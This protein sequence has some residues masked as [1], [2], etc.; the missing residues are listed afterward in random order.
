MAD[1]CQHKN[2]FGETRHTMIWSHLDDN[3]G[4]GGDIIVIT[5]PMF[6]EQKFYYT[7]LFLNPKLIEEQA[8]ESGS[9][10][11]RAGVPSNESEPSWS[12]GIKFDC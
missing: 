8:L 10:D 3:K 9:N 2:Q 5:G 6:R 7:N 12:D 11:D 1:V 4:Y